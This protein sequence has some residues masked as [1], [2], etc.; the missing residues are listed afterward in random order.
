MDNET[1]ERCAQ[2]S[3]AEWRAYFMSPTPWTLLDPYAQE[4]WRKIAHVAIAEAE[5]HDKG[6]SHE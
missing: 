4:A 5:R 3:Y 2:E 1:V 6:S